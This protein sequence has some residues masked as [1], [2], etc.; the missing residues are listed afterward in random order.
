VLIL[1]SKSF[2]EIVQRWTFRLKN[3]TLPP[4][5]VC[6]TFDDGYL[7]NLTVAQPILEKYQ[8][9][10]TIY[11]ATAFSEGLNMWNDRVLYLFSQTLCDEINIS[12]EG[13]SLKLEEWGSR[14]AN[15]YE[16]LVKLKYLEPKQRL[17]KVN[18]LYLINPAIDEQEKLMMTPKQV[19]TIS[20]SGFEIGAHTHTHPILSVLD[21]DEQRNEILRSK[22]LL[23]EWTGQAVKHFAYPNGIWEKDLDQNVITDTETRNEFQKRAEEAGRQDDDPFLMDPVQTQHEQ[24]P[25]GRKA[26]T[27]WGDMVVNLLGNHIS[28]ACANNFILQDI[29]GPDKVKEVSYVFGVTFEKPEP[30]ADSEHVKKVRVLLIREDSLSQLLNLEIDDVKL[31]SYSDHHKMR[32]DHLKLLSEYWKWTKWSAPPLPQLPGPNIVFVLVIAFVDNSF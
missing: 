17:E 28:A 15:A 12:P 5:A 1:A 24:S 10:A 11:I 18:Q 25:P 20:K 14:R 22:Q 6:I 7:N 29:H 3:G 31:Q 30:T 9:P 23:E 27:N 32:F 26:Q 4:N 8:I 21:I 13:K 19:A 2:N 16:T